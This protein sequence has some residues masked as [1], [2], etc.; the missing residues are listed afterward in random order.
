MLVFNDFYQN[1]IDYKKNIYNIIYL[2]IILYIILKR[3]S[4]KNHNKYIDLQIYLKLLFNFLI[5]RYPITMNEV[6]KMELVMCVTLH[7]DG[8]LELITEAE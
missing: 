3:K 5:K 8:M 2:M 4:R 6:I 1:I 7:H